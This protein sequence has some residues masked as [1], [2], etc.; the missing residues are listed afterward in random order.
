MFW[1]EKL[2][3]IVYRLLQIIDFKGYLQG[4]SSTN[5]QLITVASRYT[6]FHP[7]YKAL[8]VFPLFSRIKS[9]RGSK[10][11]LCVKL[12]FRAPGTL[13]KSLAQCLL[14]TSRGS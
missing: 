8:D 4:A 9:F 10:P 3:T 5:A 13:I 11:K 2:H 12:E 14:C 6:E 1:I 7:I